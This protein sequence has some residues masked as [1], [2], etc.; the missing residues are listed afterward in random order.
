MFV[1]IHTYICV[2]VCIYIY[3]CMCMYIYMYVCMYVCIYIYIYIYKT[4]L[5]LR[6]MRLVP[7]AF[8]KSNKASRVSAARG[9]E[10]WTGDWLILLISWGSLDLCWG[11]SGPPW[12]AHRSLVGRRGAIWR[13]SW[14]AVDAVKS[15]KANILKT[16]VFLKEWGDFWLLGVP[17]GASWTVWGAFWAV[18]G[19]PWVVLGSLVPL[20]AF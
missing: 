16:Y 8:R 5:A 10:I 7:N 17:F 14:D 4:T 15:K 3:I 1:Y 12:A 19:P 6:A 18:L 20:G 11:S 13:A 2:Y 9:V